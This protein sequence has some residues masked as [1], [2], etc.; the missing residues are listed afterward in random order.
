[1]AAEDDG[2]IL[3]STA[4]SMPWQIERLD[5]GHLSKGRVDRKGLA[6]AVHRLTQ[7]H[8]K[9]FGRP[10]LDQDGNLKIKERPH[11]AT[12]LDRAPEH[13]H[14]FYA[15]AK[16]KNSGGSF[17]GWFLEQLRF[18]MP[19]RKADR[20]ALLTWFSEIHHAAAKPLPVLRLADNEVYALKKVK[21]PSLSDKSQRFRAG[22]LSKYVRAS[23]YAMRE[24]RRT[25]EVVAGDLRQVAPHKYDPRSVEDWRSLRAAGGRMRDLLSRNPVCEQLHDML[26]EELEVF[27]ATSSVQLLHHGRQATRVEKPDRPLH[28]MHRMMAPESPLVAVRMRRIASGYWAELVVES[29]CGDQCTSILLGVC[30]ARPDLSSGPPGRGYFVSLTEIPD[31][32]SGVPHCRTSSRFTLGTRI[33]AL[34]TGEGSLQLHRDGRIIGTEHNLFDKLSMANADYHLVCDLTF[35]V[36][37]VS[38]S[39]ACPRTSQSL[40]TDIRQGLAWLH[41]WL[42]AFRQVILAALA[43]AE[44]Q[45]ALN[46]VR[47]LASVCHENVVAYKE[48]FWDDKTRCLCIVQECAD[49]GDLLQQINRCKQERAYLR[50]ADV[51]RYLDGMCQGLKALHDLRILHRDL[52][53]ANVFLSHSRDGLIAK[54]GDFN[55]SK[56]AKRGLCMTQTG[57]PYYASPE[58]H[59]APALFS[60]SRP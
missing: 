7:M 1:M 45:N 33:A 54:L 31:C 47:L 34:I 39:S 56:V 27:T 41:R 15:K 42:L 43:S 6:H 40:R 3:Y 46:E 38:V 22:T 5:R 18:R 44:K 57:T 49:A 55:V 37:G 36:S 19:G 26:L 58:V 13:F 30:S 4:R 25:T 52:K 50:E 23:R 28:W 14:S 2:G 20:G 59:F 8:E 17:G 35:D 29:V 32:I 16:G 60:K 51:W 53:C 11:F 9:T 24:R 10:L 12:L 48:A 21:L